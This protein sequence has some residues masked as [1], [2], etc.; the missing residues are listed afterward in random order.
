MTDRAGGVFRNA[1]TSML[2][3][4]QSGDVLLVNSEFT[5]H[6]GMSQ[7]D[8]VG[9]PWPNLLIEAD[10]DHGWEVHRDALSGTRRRSEGP[11][12]VTGSDPQRVV[13]E[14]RALP[15]ARAG[16]PGGVI[17]A[18]AQFEEERLRAVFELRTDSAET[19][20]WTLNLRTGRLRELFGPSPLGQLL[21]GD[22][23]TLEDFLSRV[24]SDDVARLRDAIET[25]NQGRDYEQQFRMFDLVG[26]ERWLWARAR[27]VSGE[28]PW[29]VGFV[30]DVTDRVQLVRRLSDRRR[31]EAAQGRQVTEL[32]AK[33][34]SATTAD[35][36]TGLLA[37][38]FVPIFD[39]ANAAVMLVDDNVLRAAP[40]SLERTG[41][42]G[43]V[44]GTDARDS[45]YPMG[46]VAQDRQ[47]RFFESRAE[48]LERFPDVHE[49]IGHTSSQSWAIVP[50]FGDRRVALGVWQVAWDQPH[51][52]TPDERALML[53]VAGLAGQALQRVNRQQAELE[54][55]DAIQRRMLPSQLP[56]FD[57]IDVAVRYLPARAGWRVCGDFYDIIR[58]PERRVGLLVG[59]VQGHGVEAAAAMGQ[60]RIAFRAYAAN[61]SDPGVVLAETNRLLTETGEIVFATCGYLVLDL[62]SGE[63]HAAWAGQPP[64]L[65][66]TNEDFTTWQPETGPPVG[67][68]SNSKYPVTTRLLGGDETLLM[69]SD[70]LVESSRV[71]MDEGLQRVGRALQ[72]MATDVNGA[73]TSLASLTPAGR[74]DDIAFLIARMVE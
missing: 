9:F 30:D 58:L 28:T 74:G 66:T 18:L 35:E 6:T 40:S 70:G 24:H 37:E 71:R 49:R 59:D 69:C 43:V 20:L 73:A 17:V 61:Q 12:T 38:D 19:A 14:A 4:D 22:E 47:P 50:I 26:D 60:I 62:D 3:A 48:V 68:D 72:A 32:A 45:R 21:V 29:L 11:V 53:T 25:S 2:V 57:D 5:D 51:H 44:D 23:A 63:M 13:I 65:V 36:V 8:V 64:V 39:G 41:L 52:A 27:Y 10:V 42:T 1:P 46:A 15:G 55:A 67:V 33:L 34:V 56:D 54:L 31:I 7:T 16:E